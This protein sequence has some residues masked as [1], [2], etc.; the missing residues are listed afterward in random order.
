MVQALQTDRESP[1]LRPGF[2]ES[3]GLRLGF[4]ESPGL[5]LGFEESPGLRPG[6]VWSVVMACVAAAAGA[7][8]GPPNF[9][10]HVLPVFREKCCSC[11]NPDKKSGGLDLTS[12]GQTMAGGS[13]GDV[14]DP[15]DADGSYLYQLVTHE[16]EPTMP[17]ESDKLSAASLELIKGWIAG[18]SLERNGSKPVARKQNAL[19]LDGPVATTPDGPPVMPPRLPLEVVTRGRRPTTIT[20]LAAS[21]HGDVVALGSRQ[22]VLLYHSGSLDLLGVLP[23]PEGVVRVVRFSRNAK[24]LLAAGGLA[25]KSG[26][27]VVWDVAT[28]QRVAEVGEEFDEVLAADISADQKFVA[29]GGP[30]KVVRL[31]KTADGSVAQEIRKHTDWVTA[32]E[33]SP[34]GKR[35]ATG[36]RAG[37]LFL[38]ETRGAREA[39][40]LKGHSAAITAVAWR[41][42]GKLVA[43]VSA[44]GSVRLWNVK[45][46]ESIKNWSAHGG[47]AEWLAW[48]PDG[49]LVTTGRDAK[50]KLWKPDGALERELGPLADIG[51]RVAAT[52]DGARIFAG[53]W[54]G[55]LTAFATGDG[56]KAGSLDT[57]PPRLEQRIAAA[58]KALAEVA[59]AEQAVAEQARQAAE[60]LQLAESQM[61]AARQAAEQAEAALEAAKARQAEAGKGVDRWKAELEFARQP[62]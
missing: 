4:E 34:D 1:G 3:P 38:W 58:E 7:A 26:R 33:F 9:E 24:L 20:A 47:G 30:A 29:L 45:T 17:P 51:T 37:N 59:A 61:A 53:D 57:N 16:S 55:G 2:E 31:L 25:A 44:D 35:L 50:A 10:E 12:F 14:I 48:L 46:G 11:H 5:R 62:R 52:S 56:G 21:P 39:G 15:G 18:G 41:P 40:T 36:D 42:D 54:T 32:L 28:A 6:F 49:R 19:A 8:D 27:V 60:A 13:S 23:F 43:S 22:Q